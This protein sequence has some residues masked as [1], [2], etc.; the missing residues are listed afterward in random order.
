MIH[1]NELVRGRIVA[2]IQGVIFDCDGVLVES[3]GA[4]VFFYNWFRKQ[5]GLGPM[6]PED[7]WY[8]HISHVSDSLRRIIPADRLDEAWA[9]R[10]RFDYRQVLPHMR[11]MPH[12]LDVLDWLRAR[13]IRM[14]INTS[15]TNTLDM[16]LEYMGLD[17][18]FFPAVASMSVATPKPHPEGVN[19]ILRSW[20]LR[21]DQV[22]YI[23][24]SGTDEHTA[25]NAG[26]RFWSF[27]NESLHAQALVPDFQT[28][29]CCLR[30]NYGY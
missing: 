21:R 16:V 24:D 26:V 18:Y 14:G 25:H 22:V 15:R 27:Q 23:G 12:L 13:G 4:N 1:L 29:L 2:D 19:R 11:R 28:M 9:M 10:K 30:A 7:E 8:T 20:G 17:D 3:R 6:T 5:F